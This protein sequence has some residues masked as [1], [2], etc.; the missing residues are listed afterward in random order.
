M[1]LQVWL[2]YGIQVRLES[3]VLIRRVSCTG[4]FFFRCLP[5]YGPVAGQWLLDQICPSI[6]SVPF[7]HWVLPSMDGKIFSQLNDCEQ[8]YLATGHRAYL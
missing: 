1:F 3:N 4:F 6:V 2:T 5:L 7:L 8:A